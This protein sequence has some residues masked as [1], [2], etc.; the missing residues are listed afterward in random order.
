L[1]LS[2]GERAKALLEAVESDLGGRLSKSEA[3]A[4]ALGSELESVGK[5]GADAKLALA[6]AVVRVE[7]AEG[8]LAAGQV[9]LSALQEQLDIV[10]VEREAGVISTRLREA[11]AADTQLR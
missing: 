9:E 10:L 6:E 11:E 2:E 7:A 5:A 3:K 4:D 8:G 1:R